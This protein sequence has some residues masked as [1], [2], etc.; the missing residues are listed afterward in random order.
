MHVTGQHAV[1]EVYNPFSIL[2]LSERLKEFK[3]IMGDRELYSGDAIVSSLVNTGIMLVIEANLID[4]WSD[5]DTLSVVQD[6]AA[7]K[8]ELERFIGAWETSNDILPEFKAFISDYRS[9]FEDLSLWLKQVEIGLA[10][11]V[12]ERTH[13]GALSLVSEIM[14]PIRP[15]LAEFSNRLE[16]LRG[17]ISGD[18]EALHK[19][20]TRKEL[21]HE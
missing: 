1:F 5:V 13:E 20:F 8:S 3:I 6:P 9:F 12:S 19:H 18:R 14:K 16:T 17:R 11:L 21:H 4:R 2:Q 10:N 15:T 7:L